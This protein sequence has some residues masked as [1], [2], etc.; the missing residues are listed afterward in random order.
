VRPEDAAAAFYQ[1]EALQ[2]AGDLAGARDALE[3]SLKLMP[4]QVPARVML[5][6]VYLGLKDGKAAQDQ[7]EA[8]LLV[9]D[10]SVDGHLGLARAMMASGSAKDAV[11][12]LEPLTKVHP[13]NAGVWEL[14]SQ[15]YAALGK[16]AEAEAAGS[17]AAQLK[18]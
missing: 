12:E 17:K 2:K 14:L 9:D 10:R 13:D 3:A 8:A 1:G 5:G 18:R 16:K 15:A 6:N 11:E 7:F 4:S